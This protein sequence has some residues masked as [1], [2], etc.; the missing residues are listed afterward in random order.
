MVGGTTTDQSVA[1]LAPF[2][3]LVFYGMAGRKPPMPIDLRNLLGHST[4]V[5]GMWLPHVFRLPGD[6]YGTAL[7]ELFDLA[8]SGELRV[9]AGGEYAL[10]DARAAHEALRSRGTVGKLLLDPTR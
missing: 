4:T 1:A 8:R 9:V 7:A 5:T 10:S 6:L 2:G 3:R